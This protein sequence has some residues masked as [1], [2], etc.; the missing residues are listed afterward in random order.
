MLLALCVTLAPLA[1]AAPPPPVR[2]NNHRDVALE[3]IWAAEPLTLPA[4]TLRKAAPDAPPNQSADVLLRAVDYRYDAEHRL[5]RRQH[6]VVR[7]LTADGIEQWGTLRFAYAPW[8]EARP[9]IQ[10]RVITADGRELQL[11]QGTLS[12]G[13]P[14][15]DAL[16]VHDNKELVAPLPGVGRGA[17]IEVVSEVHEDK[18]VF[19]TPGASGRIYFISDE[20]ARQLRVRIATPSAMQLDYHLAQSDLKPTETTSQGMHQLTFVTVP[21]VATADLSPDTIGR[22]TWST[23]GSWQA[24]ARSYL[25]IVEAARAQKLPDGALVAP[26]GKGVTRRQKIDKLLSDLR[27]RVRYTGLE[28]GQSAVVPY[29]PP[30]VW[31]RE[32]GDCKDMAVLLVTALEQAGVH[33]RVALLHPGTQD[34]DPALPGLDLFDHVIVYVP[35]SDGE[36]ALWIDPTATGFGAGTLPMPDVERSAL[37]IDPDTTQPTLTASR[38]DNRFVYRGDVQAQLAMFGASTVTQRMTFS[39]AAAAYMRGR[40]DG[41][42]QQHLVALY[43]GEMKH[44][45]GGKLDDVKITG[46]DGGDA[47]TVTL[48]ISDAEQLGAG[49]AEAAVLLPGYEILGYLPL[50]ARDGEARAYRVRTAF[51]VASTATIEAPKGYVASSGL[52]D[53]SVPLGPITWRQSVAK[54]PGKDNVVTAT[55]SLDLAKLDWSVADTSAFREALKT[56]MTKPKQAI[57]FRHGATALIASGSVEAG[58]SLFRDE[59][60]KAPKDAPTRAR[61]AIALADLGLGEVARGE[62]DRALKDA[63]R[64][65][66]V[67]WAAAMV[68]SADML[69]RLYQPGWDRAGALTILRSLV[70]LE[71]TWQEG[72]RRLAQALSVD[73]RGQFVTSG[74]EL[75]ESLGLYR[76]LAIDEK[77]AATFEPYALMLWHSGKGAT[78][79]DDG[80]QLGASVRGM[81]VAAMARHDG[82]PQVLAALTQ[83]A[84]SEQQAGLEGAYALLLAQRD[85]PT[86]RALAD[87]LLE[88]FPSSQSAQRAHEM[89]GGLERRPSGVATTT[90]EGAL[91]ALLARIAEDRS[92]AGIVRAVAKA[93][94]PA[95]WRGSEES[96]LSALGLSVAE[97]DATPGIFDF[98]Y[99]LMWHHGQRI[100][101][102]AGT[103]GW[104]LR[105][106][107]G[108][109]KASTS[110]VSYWIPGTPSAQLV[111]LGA[112]FTELGERARLL[113]LAGDL[114]SARKWLDWAREAIA[115]MADN[116]DL[117]GVWPLGADA[118]KDD[119]VAAASWFAVQSAHPQ[120]DA[121]SVAVAKLA[122]WPEATRGPVLGALARSADPIALSRALD[123]LPTQNT[124]SELVRCT[125]LARAGKLAEAKA[126]AQA[127]VAADP[128]SKQWSMTLAELAMREG[129]VAGAAALL[130]PL[131]S[132]GID[133]AANNLAW[134]ELFVEKASDETERIAQ[135]AVDRDVRIGGDA[136]AHASLNTLTMIQLERGHWTDAVTT[137]K[138]TIID[139][140]DVSPADWLLVGRL[141][142]GLGYRDAAKK[143][144]ARVPKEDE[145]AS[146]WELAQRRLTKLAR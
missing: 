140:T 96:K 30:E 114:A 71:P 81:W 24:M 28:L 116:V 67:L 102:A 110:F 66:L 106:E 131:V 9:T 64:D 58:L 78:L 48:T 45:F 97:T 20:P 122:S 44:T 17:T 40:L 141:A 92:P 62:V 14:R 25:A 10:A 129:D 27:A 69:G 63:P 107:S 56:F 138:R 60:A 70:K 35:A 50:D 6:L 108:I 43:E 34:I 51:D 86:A 80:A 65:H 124:V 145:P 94:A 12:E 29:T 53:E 26:S 57:V 105:V 38:G 16:L 133:A 75:E 31:R 120:P 3:A 95:H 47:V 73:A 76:A 74:P 59:L 121:I 55:L 104:R 98:S 83:L 125:A 137:L 13:T 23:G 136:I 132:A 68:H 21:T 113:A 8:H 37:I 5:T 88:R 91:L 77:D 19:D 7:V 85:Y 139:A 130:K 52:G 49:L 115:S 1:A 54:V 39:G 32:Y 99:D 41:L 111:A 61:L 128:A 84:A 112:N 90:P 72:R 143:A 46:L 127:K 135:R 11:D 126:L 93:T 100:V 22:L 36:A 18:K 117:D 119:L 89:I 146:S 142:E 103:S 15:G 109:G 33:A 2:P 4:D 123:A 82:V 87:A 79:A 42:D 144:Y 118:T 101:D 134:Y